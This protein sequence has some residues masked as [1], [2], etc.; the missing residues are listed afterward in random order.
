MPKGLVRHQFNVL[1]AAKSF[2]S[3]L[4]C[5]FDG[6]LRRDD[7]VRDEEADAQ[8]WWQRDLRG[9]RNWHDCGLEQPRLSLIDDAQD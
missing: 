1:T 2:K 8:F 6:W 9:P 3:N 5:P 4:H 7:A